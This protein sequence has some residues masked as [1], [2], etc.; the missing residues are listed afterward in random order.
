MNFWV[1]SFNSFA[2]V[3]VQISPATDKEQL[4]LVLL[5]DLLVKM[6]HLEPVKRITPQSILGH[7]FVTSMAAFIAG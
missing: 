1:L 5:M 2:V 7:S 3:V 6:L 4:D